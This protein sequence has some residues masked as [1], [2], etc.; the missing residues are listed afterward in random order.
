MKAKYWLALFI[1]LAS[2]ATA[3]AQTSPDNAAAFGAREA[4]E[5]VSLSP[6]GT[7]VAYLTPTDVGSILVVRGVTENAVPRAV[8]ASNRVG[9]RL[10]R[11]H[12]VSNARLVC[13]IYGTTDVDGRKV[14][15]SRLFAIDIDGTNLK[16]ISSRQNANSR[17]LLLGGG[18]VIDWL[19]GQDGVVLMSRPHLPDDR[20]GS[21]LGSSSEGLA[22]DLVDTRTG[23]V[24]A[25]EAPRR[26]AFTYLSDGLGAVRIYGSEG[27]DTGGMQTGVNTYFFRKAGESAWQRLSQ[28][29][30]EA[31]TGFMPLAVSPTLNIAYGFKH[32]DGR[33]AIYSMALDGTSTERMVAS[34][35]DVDIDDLVQIGRRNRVV[36]ATYQ[37]DARS[38]I[39]FDVA[40]Q[41]LM[42]SLGK[43]VP[44]QPLMRIVDSSIDER[45]L[46]I[47]AG[48]DD[49]PGV[50][51]LYDRDKRDLHILFPARPQ[52]EGRSLGHMKA[53][54]YPAADGTL[55]P[56]YLTL[57]P[58]ITSAKGL[59][60][61]VLPHGG[62]ASRDEWGFD[63]LPQYYAS[64]GYA[65]LQPQFRGSSGYG[66]SWF[67]KNGFQSWQIAIGDVTDAG[68]WLVKQGI[69]NP[70][71]LA[72]V[73]WSYGG[74]AA[75]QS[76]VVA[77]DLFKAVVAIAPVTDL[78]MLKRERAGWTDDRLSQQYIGSGPHIVAGS[79]AQNAQRIKVPVLLIHGTMDAN[80]DYAES[81]LMASRLRSAGA[82]VDL[83]TFPGLDHQLENS[84]AREKLLASS[85]SFI[86]AAVAK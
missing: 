32:A 68:R 67:E 65:V 30:D 45:K 72:V 17:G 75:L 79:P 84:S 27:H 83:I 26:D 44:K 56:A 19:P 69:A 11:C 12:W 73:G 53:I 77:P 78:A 40:L 46:L 16:Q 4:V 21:K 3:F 25:V 28:Y 64:Q 71:R 15:F 82:K 81:T 20:I 58:N 55:I 9:E 47:F 57:P 39:F 5:Q 14:S 70:A 6:D 50:Y 49:D 60:A 36:G 59:P 31:K 2:S 66:D 61:I 29:N 33:N 24:R 18:D 51:Y 1:G 80:V 48:S 23:S 74:Y 7:Q 85:N 54:T 37:T 34:R 76:A 38:M 86:A 10:K 35:P 13:M 43:A 52:L 8:I 42:V 62:P 22:V 41:N 63:W